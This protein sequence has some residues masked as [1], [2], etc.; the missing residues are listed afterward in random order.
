M[1]VKRAATGNALGSN[2]VSNLPSGPETAPIELTEPHA[3]IW[4]RAKGYLTVRDN[5]SHTLYAYGLAR[6]LVACHPAAD[7]EVVL[8]AILL[9]DVGW[10]QVPPDEI[11]LGIAPGSNRP[12]LVLLHEREGARIAREIL[13]EVG[14]DAGRTEQIVTIVDGHDSRKEALGLDDSLVKDADKL[15][16]ITPHG[17]DTVMD[18]FGLDRRQATVLIRSRVH[19]HLFTDAART[20]A[21]AF[22]AIAGI[23]ASPQLIALE[24]EQELPREP[25][26]R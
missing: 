26:A 6:A 25:H 3:R 9:H 14:H 4:E 8:P 24:A 7:P 16:R 17:V 19:D 20:M 22:A 12:D 23:D 11:L 2:I 21:Q 18:W 13:Q 1:T 5:D 15:W 10:S